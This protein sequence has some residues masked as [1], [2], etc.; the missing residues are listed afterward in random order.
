MQGFPLLQWSLMNV[1][2]VIVSVFVQGTVVFGR[3]CAPLTTG[4]VN[5]HAGTF[6]KDYELNC[7]RLVE[8]QQ[9]Q[10]HPIKVLPTWTFKYSLIFKILTSPS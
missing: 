2:V 5:T 3:S 1:S 4:R 6:I 7:V 10:V 8:I 9:H